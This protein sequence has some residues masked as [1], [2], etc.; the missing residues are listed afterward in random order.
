MLYKGEY[1]IGPFKRNF[2]HPLFSNVYRS[3]TVCLSLLSKEQ[4][5]AISNYNS[6]YLGVKIVYNEPKLKLL[7][8]NYLKW[9]TRIGVQAKAIGP[10]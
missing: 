5:V 7:A 8:Q 6:N 3:G 1:L 10:Q 4:K 9:E 2:E